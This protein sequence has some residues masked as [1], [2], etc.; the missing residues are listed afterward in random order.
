M[1]MGF[2]SLKKSKTTLNKLIKLFGKDNVIINNILKI[3]VGKK[4]IEYEKKLINLKTYKI[5]IDIDIPGNFIAIK[6]DC[7]I[8]PKINKLLGVKKPTRKPLPGI[9]SCTD[10][11]KIDY[12]KF[13]TKAHNL[14]T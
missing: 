9:M 13:F 2:V 3:I 4:K 11:L 7:A 5:Y 6:F 14:D 12:D 1:Q 10:I 8:I